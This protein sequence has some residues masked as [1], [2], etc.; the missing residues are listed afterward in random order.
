[1]LICCYADAAAAAMMLPP[2]DAACRRLR[3]DAADADTLMMP[4]RPHAD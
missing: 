3:H 1:M 2:L 4:A